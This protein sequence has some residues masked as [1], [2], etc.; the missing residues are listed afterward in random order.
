VLAAVTP[1]LGHTR[2][3]RAQQP[4][5]TYRVGYL[6]EGARPFPASRLNALRELGWVEGRNLQIDARHATSQ[7]ALP[8]LAADLV[9]SKV[10][11]IMT[12][13]TPATLAARDATQKIPIVFT[14]GGDP[15]AR[16][17]VASLA[18][19]GGNVTG[20][21]GGLYGEKQMQTLKDALPRVLRVV[22]PGGNELPGLLRAAKALAMQVL[23]IELRRPED[24]DPFYAQARKLR[25]D[26]VLITD[27]AWFA[28]H[29]QRLGADATASGLPSIGYERLFAE[30][31]GLLSY[32]PAPY[33]DGLRVA[34]QA[35]KIFR[36]ANPAEIP[37]EQPTK[38]D[39]MVNLKAARTLGVTIAPGLL[40]R[41]DEVIQ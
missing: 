31:G 20:F 4:G 39:L 6:V 16:G 40:Q 13:G 7:D 21:L 36:G 2:V 28:P 41:A 27:I 17:L 8:A 33:Q 11:L 26:A 10:D 22:V 3:S 24:I 18:R 25:A 35:D 9:K 37:V 38:F 23:E 29:L 5:K 30:A 19:P 32:G 12:Q 15:V 34:A 14:L 1:L